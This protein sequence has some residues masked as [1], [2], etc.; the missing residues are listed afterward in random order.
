MDKAEIGKRLKAG[1]TIPGVSLVEQ[2]SVSV[3]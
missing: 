3:K 1:E 2:Q